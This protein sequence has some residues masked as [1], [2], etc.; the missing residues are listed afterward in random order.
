M[1]V[2]FGSRGRAVALR[3]GTVSAV[4]PREVVLRQAEAWR[5]RHFA[6]PSASAASASGNTTELGGL[7]FSWS[8]DAAVPT[9]SM[10]ATRVQVSREDG[11]LSVAAGEASVVLGRTSIDVRNGRIELVRGA[12][13][14]YRVSALS[15][16]SVEAQVVVP[17]GKGESTAPPGGP[18]ALPPAPAAEPSLPSARAGLVR[19][20]LLD[21]ARLVDAAL[22]PAAKVAIAGLHARVRRGDESLN[23]GPGK[24][25]VTREGGR[26]LV[27]LSPEFSVP[28][29]R[30]PA[31]PPKRRSPSASA[32]RSA[33]RPPPPRRLRPTCR[34]DRS[35]L[36]TLGLRD[37]DFGLFDVGATSIST[38]LHVVL[39]AD[40]KGL[41]LDGEGRVHALSIGSAALSDQPVARPRAPRSAPRATSISTAPASTSPRAIC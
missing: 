5:A 9:E 29:R 17:G 11:K 37:G 22:D 27:E 19:A 8:N 7:R 20:A 21:A 39:S 25:A 12:A 40:G 18:G 16:D 6:S 15:A 3:G 28:L 1:E 10:T 32:S 35:R 24:L 13:G 2:A 30:N 31:P 33:T 34:A 38:R 23:L 41:S 4:G 26:L 36:S 14:G